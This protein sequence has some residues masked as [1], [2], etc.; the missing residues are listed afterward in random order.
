MT[1]PGDDEDGE[2]N[3]SEQ[4]P[5]SDAPGPSQ[6]P[7]E[8]SAGAP[9][10]ADDG[11]SGS[12][13]QPGP[14]MGLNE[15]ERFVP[16]E[17]PRSAGSNERPTDPVQD[18]FTGRVD[19]YEIAS[20]EAR[21]PLD[22][23]A[24]RLANVLQTS[25]RLLLLSIALT[26]FIAQIGLAGVLVV[27]APILGGLA[28]ASAVPALILAGYF[29]YGDPTTKEPLLGLAV[30]FLLSVGFAT[31]AGVVNSVAQPFF[32]LFGIVGTTLF[33]FLI[34]GPI[35]ETVKWLAVRSYAFRTDA[36]QTVVDGVV[37][38]AMAG[39]GF[40]AIE[41]LLYILMFSVDSTAAGFAIQQDR[42]VAIATQRAFVGPGHVIFSAWAGFYLGL[43]KF[44]HGKRGPIVV[45]G[46]LIAAFIHAL[47]NTLV[48]NLSLTLVTF[49]AFLVVYHGFWFTML[50]RKLRS[51]RA[52]Y[53]QRGV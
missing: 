41:N 23:F 18:S 24:V 29:W 15:G 43:A 35:E 40:A 21:S 5:G 50:Y 42:A 6:R 9:S 46:L 28:A 33:Y 2:P 3:P 34:V 7:P 8:G 39:V 38:G 4:P 53:Q 17:G 48:T 20:W 19:L 22:R 32:Q 1:P 13:E 52:L 26:L 27:Q 36:F 51:Y 47:Y 49:L 12:S 25:K 44:N 10:T 16:R 37:Y 31:I 11:Q 30:T 14:E 45:K